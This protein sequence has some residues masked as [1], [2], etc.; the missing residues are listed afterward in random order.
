VTPEVR[1]SVVI[2]SFNRRGILSRALRSV[3]AQ[4]VA[5]LEI[6]VV[7]DGSTDG[8]PDLLAREFPDVCL[9]RQ[10][11]LGASGAR[12][13]GVAHATGDWI[14]F[15]DSDDEWAPSYLDRMSEAIRSTNGQAAFYFSNVAKP[16]SPTNLD[17]W[18][19][20]GFVPP[21]GDGLSQ[22]PS[23]WISMDRQPM[24]LPFAVFRKD[25]YRK[26]GGLWDKLT[27]G[28]DTHL[29]LKL[30]LCWPACAVSGEGGRVGEDDD[31]LNRLTRTHGAET[32]RH[33]ENVLLLNRD[34]L[35]RGPA[36]RKET[37]RLLLSRIADAHW[38]L[39]RLAMTRGDLLRGATQ[40]I[41][42]IS[43]DPRRLWH[44]AQKIW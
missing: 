43:T 4:S 9:I 19:Q 39:F 3:L 7:D 18:S 21:T 22:D 5:P 17:L 28:E 10:Q 6:I 11:R 35:D 41:A 29:F 33:W 37:R 31:P 44:S 38:R 34:L 40:F 2:P 30:G 26:S 14:A 23:S 36:M 24:L 25:A 32:A 1:I 16:A 8:T 20:C 15:L 13:A 42:S 27:T 12:N